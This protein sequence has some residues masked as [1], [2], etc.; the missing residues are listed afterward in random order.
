MDALSLLLLLAIESVAPVFFA[1]PLPVF[2]ALLPLL[3][4]ALLE[5][6]KFFLY[7]QKK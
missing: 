6:F 1:L 3:H 4:Q 7:R 5:G 2:H